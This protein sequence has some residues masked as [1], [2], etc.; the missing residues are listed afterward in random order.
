LKFGFHYLPQVNNA[1]NSKVF[2][3]NRSPHNAAITVSF[4]YPSFP[5][6]S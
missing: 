2:L 1:L 6:A 5:K 4:L 3:E